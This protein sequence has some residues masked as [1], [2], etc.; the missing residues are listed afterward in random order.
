MISAYETCGALSGT[1][2]YGNSGDARDK[3]A[4]RIFEEISNN[5]PNL[6][7][8]MNLHIQEAQKTSI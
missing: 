7:K 2:A 8:N 5:F 3:G 4:E 1:P 6:M